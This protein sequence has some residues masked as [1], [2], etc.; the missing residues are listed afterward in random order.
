[1]TSFSILKLLPERGKIV[2]GEILFDGKEIR[3]LPEE[4]MI[5][6]RGNE[7]SMI[8]QEPMTSLNPVM[9]IGDQIAESLIL[10]QGLDKKAARLRTVEL[11]KLVGFPRAEEIVDEYPH[12]LSG[13]MRQRAMIAMAVACNPKLLIADE[14]TTALDVTI[15]A[16]ILELMREV[17]EKFDTVDPADHPRFGRRGRNGRPGRGDVR[18][19]GGGGGGRDPPV[20]TA[21][22]SVHGGPSEVRSQPGGGAKA[23]VFDSRKRSVAR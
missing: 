8:F 9:T 1:M 14:P 16:Q 20:R 18:G 23:L 6:I 13:G 10:H 22:A 4:E 2:E 19:K 7:I 3:I 5:R 15:Q 21:R 17:K 12:Q 11:L